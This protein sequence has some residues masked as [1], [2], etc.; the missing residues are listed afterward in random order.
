M[1]DVMN[2]FLFFLN[3]RNFG[4]LS[5]GEEAEEDESETIDFVQKNSSKSKSVH[6]VIDDP[7]LSKEPVHIEKSNED[8]IE[9]HPV[10]EDD[11]DAVK[12]KTDRVRDKL[13]KASEKGGE[14]K[15]APTESEPK[16]DIESNS[17]SDEFTNELERERKLKR[18]KKA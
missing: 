8:Y 16:A 10:Q 15:K 12:E 3:R 18:Q 11:D 2:F 13:K 17:D 1:L 14:K 9:E 4:L 7:K 6:D 5:F